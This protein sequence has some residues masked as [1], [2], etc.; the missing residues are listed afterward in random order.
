MRPYDKCRF[1]LFAGVTKICRPRCWLVFLNTILSGIGTVI[2]PPQVSFLVDRTPEEFSH[3][4]PRRDRPPESSSLTHPKRLSR[5]EPMELHLRP[6]TES[7][8]QEIAEKTGRPA[9]DLAEN[10]LPVYLQ[11]LSQTPEILN[12]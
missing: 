6:E 11:E 8:I 3:N 12:T 2:D 10:P 4:S 1:V 5:L 7:R 9:A